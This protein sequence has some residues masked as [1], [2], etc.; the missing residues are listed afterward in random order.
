M[1]VRV[2]AA[3]RRGRMIPLTAAV[4]RT[5]RTSE[6]WPAVHCSTDEILVKVNGRLRRFKIPPESLRPCGWHPEPK[7]HTRRRAWLRAQPWSRKCTDEEPCAMCGD[8][9]VEGG[10]GRE[11]PR[12]VEDS[13]AEQ[14]SER[15]ATAG[16]SRLARRR[17]SSNHAL[18]RTLGDVPGT[19]CAPESR[20]RS[21]PC[22][23]GT[24]PANPAEAGNH[25]G[26]RMPRPSGRHWPRTRG[27]ARTESAPPSASSSGQTT[28]ATRSARPSRAG[29]DRRERAT[30]C[31]DSPQTTAQ[32]QNATGR[33]R[34]DT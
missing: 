22:T 8:G 9:D 34:P 2:T 23:R 14:G 4:R 25:H 19:I 27:S 17:S 30:G 12:G 32:L 1:R 26:T 15:P 7:E 29:S 24:S 21:A 20:S 16:A 28:L 11:R 18:A 6:P 13:R 5:F 3:E 31:G 10:D 33:Q